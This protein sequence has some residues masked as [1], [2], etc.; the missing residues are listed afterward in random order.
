MT[1]EQQAERLARWLEHPDSE[2]PDD[3]DPEVLGAVFTLSPKTAPAARVSVDDILAGVKEG[4]FA[5][6]PEAR[7]DRL[8][9]GGAAE[10]E[11]TVRPKPRTWRWMVPAVGAAL[12]ASLMAL[13]VIP[14]SRVTQ[15]TMT[16]PE[17]A[18]TAPRS[19]AKNDT[20]APPPSPA[21]TAGAP[22]R[23]APP[24]AAPVAPTAQ[25]TTPSSPLNRLQADQ[26]NTPA[27]DV[28]TEAPPPPPMP[29]ATTG[30]AIPAE[31][32]QERFNDAPVAQAG[33]A[34][35]PNAIVAPADGIAEMDDLAEAKDETPKAEKAEE[36]VAVASKKA[37]SREA[38]KA[39][40]G[41]PAAAA[42]A[43]APAASV[44]D[45]EAPVWPM[46]Y[47]AGWYSNYPD[48]AA[49]YQTAK[50][51]E[52]QGSWAAAAV[53]YRSLMSDPRSI[54]AQDAAWYSARAWFQ[55]GQSTTALE[56]I[57]QGLRRSAA[58]T[59]Y[60]ARL[61]ALKGDILAAGGRQVQAQAAYNE[62]SALNAGR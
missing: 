20:A 47:N 33:P 5:A 36:T 50:A 60:R 28:A 4:P 48:V 21:P 42:P 24:A 14:V 19:A 51:S 22:M 34:P 37:S 25:T 38:A 31:E 6:P 59:P 45:N 57:D 3:L 35:E 27:Q 1:E 12:A 43:S 54:V 53:A 10:V 8:R 41:R 7:R 46:D 58:N 2:P 44:A 26:P 13:V 23:S 56:A 11:R 61:F 15:K 55:S 29:P 32:M 52:A 62:A 16:M 17:M 9:S 39:P 49:V 18:A 30:N 40:A